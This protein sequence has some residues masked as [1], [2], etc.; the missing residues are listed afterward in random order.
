[1]IRFGAPLAGFTWVKSSD[2]SIPPQAVQGGREIDGKPLYICR[3][4]H[5]G[6]LHI[7]KTATH[8][9]G[10]Y[11]AYGGNLFSY[12]CLI[13]VGKEVFNKECYVLCGPATQLRWIECKGKMCA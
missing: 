12:W 9:N 11:I 3:Q 13:W 7:G 2:G 5:K 4:W 6:G 10:C 8:L 1:M